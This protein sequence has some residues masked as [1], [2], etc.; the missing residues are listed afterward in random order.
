MVRII[1]SSRNSRVDLLWYEIQRVSVHT[2]GLSTGYRSLNWSTL[3][4]LPLELHFAHTCLTTCYLHRA[5]QLAT[6]TQ[7]M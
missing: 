7:H 2:S 3:T 1:G 5:T 6:I 4:Q